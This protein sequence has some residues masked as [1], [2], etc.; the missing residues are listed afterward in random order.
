MN[1]QPIS[2]YFSQPSTIAYG[3]MG[4]GGEW[5]NEP[6]GHQHVQQ[7]NA[8]I[9]AALENGINFFDHADIY[10]LGKAEQVFGQ[11]LAQR[12]D[13]REQMIIQSKCAIRFADQQGPK[14]FDFSQ[15]YIQQSV[16]GIL[17]R[18]NTDYL[19][20]LLLHRPDPLMEPEEVAKVFEALRNSGKVRH[21]G[22]SNMNVQQ[23]AFLQ[24]YLD[25]PIIANQIELHMLRL[26]WLDDIVMANNSDGGGVNFGSGTIE[27]C[28]TKHIQIQ[29]WGSLCQG[30]LTG[31][32]STNQ[33]TH[34]QQTAEL[35]A[36][37]AADYQTSKEAI[38]LAFIMR[39][40]AGIQPIIGTTNVERIAAC[41]QAAQVN[42]SREH[43]YAL[44]VSARGNELP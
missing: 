31:R 40:P 2:R 17:S 20:I 9:D 1:K 25:M 35:V 42:L 41:A 13:L 26:D 44:Y 33:P 5:N 38:V 32:D 24:N 14:R 23:M 11:V 34:I 18:L 12:S 16:D 15:Q 36:R 4:L 19:D 39:H 3:C 29:S 27:Y 6:Y 7:A 21:F 37:L 43:W 22:V 8:V 28:R 30:L 10:T